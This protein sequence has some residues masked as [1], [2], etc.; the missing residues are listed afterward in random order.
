MKKRISII[1]FSLLI[2]LL[3][4]FIN[5]DFKKGVPTIFYNGNI[6]TLNEDQPN[7]SAM[8]VEDGRIVD[9]GELEELSVHNK[10]NVDKVDLQGKTVMPGFIDV[11]THFALSMFLEG[12]H[13]LSG[14]KH[15]NNASVWRFFEKV[16]G[17]RPSDEWVVCRGLDPL[18][19]K[20]LQVPTIQY[21]DSIAPANPVI[22]F[23]QS[24][25]S[26]WANSQ[27][28][29]LANIT[30]NTKNPSKH[31]YYD[32]DVNGNFTGLIVEQEAFKPFM[33]NLT[34]EYLNAKFLGDMS[35][36][37][38]D[39]Y[40]RNGNTTIVSTGLTINDEKPL[41]LTRHLSDESQSFF[42]GLLSM[43]GVLPQRK[44]MPRHFIYMRHD[45]A[46]LLPEKRVQN[47]FYD[48]IGIKHWY[49]GSP[50]I[51]TMYMEEPYLETPLTIDELH[52]KEGSK[53][54]ALI[55]QAELKEFIKKYHEQDWQIAI[56]TQGDAA[57]QEVLDVYEDLDSELDFSQSRHRLEHCMLME[58]AQLDLVKKL[59]LTPSFHINHLYFYGEALKTK[60][61]G[62]ERTS[63]S[64]PINSA[65]Q[66]GI[67]STLHA[68]QPMFESQPFRLI[69]T[70]VERKTKEGI[71]LGET[72]K[73]NLVE[74]IKSLTIF[75]A[76]QIEMEDKLGSLEKGKYADFI[77]VS[78]DPFTVENTELHTIQCLK[79]YINGTS[80]E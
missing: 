57:I 11:H 39:D 29:E 73:I 42:N 18:L 5:R 4:F 16:V 70:A 35:V 23:S 20:D 25:H 80:I 49:D 28:F 68:D 22:I 78:H 59:N 3:C 32:K 60:I 79:T 17:D 33:E 69:Q 56:H 36:K 48:V 66:K 62:E 63:N 15:E 7:A 34:N 55:N 24:L 40:A 43:I 67:I 77:I 14:F 46:H 44:Q 47:D 41:I 52:I 31:S 50:Y 58:E 71:L 38:M 26:Y 45:M 19:V 74:A 9:I 53:G 21:L 30:K 8:Y 61:L 2:I 65:L 75:A 10:E 37:V 76:W 12:M 13:N 1:L 54:K 51:G 6:I 27:A 64:F 72:E